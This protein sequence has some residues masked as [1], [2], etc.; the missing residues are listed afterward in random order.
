MTDEKVFTASN[1]TVL[2]RWGFNVT[3]DSPWV[4]YDGIHE[5]RK[6]FYQHLR[7]QELGRWRDP[8]N[9]HMVCYPSTEPEG[10]EV[11]K[12]WVVD[13]ATGKSL[14]A[15]EKHL[16]LSYDQFAARVSE[17]ARRYFEAHPETKPW[18]NAQPGEVWLLTVGGHTP[19]LV[20]V[21]DNRPDNEF[22]NA[23]GLR[24][25]VTNPEITHAE[26]IYPK[27]EG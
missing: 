22:S 20:L 14:R 7:D 2:N 27:D 9:P 11:R 16:P 26:R 25:P 15:W 3:P 4:L 10:S 13:E 5:A 23:E 12:I 8:E 1:G 17:T 19:E 24:L 18:H 21:L 6:E